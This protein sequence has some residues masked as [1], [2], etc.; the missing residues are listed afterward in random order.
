MALD[1]GIVVAEGLINA[2]SIVAAIVRVAK[3]ADWGTF[4]AAAKVG[5]VVMVHAVSAANWPPGSMAKVIFASAPLFIASGAV[6][7]TK[8]AP[9]PEDVE[10]A[11]AA[12]VRMNPGTTTT[13]VSLGW[14]AWFMVKAMTS[15]VASPR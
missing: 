3:F 12:G 15:A 2:E 4:G 11:A 5:F 13:I 8:L 10:E 14:R 9:Q 7:A 1:D 6:V